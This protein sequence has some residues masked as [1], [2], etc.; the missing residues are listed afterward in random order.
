M[1][2]STSSLK[3]SAQVTVVG[4]SGGVD[5][6]RLSYRRSSCCGR[7]WKKIAS[8]SFPG[9]G[10]SSEKVVRNTSSNVANVPLEK[11]REKDGETPVKITCLAAGIPAF[12]TEL[13]VS[14]LLHLLERTRQDNRG[15]LF[16]SLVV[17][18]VGN[19][20]QPKAPGFVALFCN[21]QRCGDERAERP[22]DSSGQ[23]KDDQEQQAGND[24]ERQEVAPLEAPCL[25][26]MENVPIG[27]DCKT[28][29]D[30]GTNTDPPVVLHVVQMS[31]VNTCFAPDG[32]KQE[33]VSP[34]PDTPRQVVRD[35]RRRQRKSRR[36]SKVT[37]QESSHVGDTKGRNTARSK[38]SARGSLWD[39]VADCSV[40][41]AVVLMGYNAWLEY[42]S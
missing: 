23:E 27:D 30:E 36:I 15:Y 12:R 1:G 9:E 20:F 24:G 14:D 29:E 19:I 28:I 31:N 17:G 32:V 6:I 3:T 10:R 34:V 35:R 33:L 5:A 16:F 18:A 21:G 13:T 37:G 8:F 4:G 11:L 42:N 40:V 25:S 2:H 38:G 39:L 26:D 41:A 7:K 22:V